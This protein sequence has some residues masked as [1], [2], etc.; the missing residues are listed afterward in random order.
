MPL[1]SISVPVS[2]QVLASSAS[3]AIFSGTVLNAKDEVLLK[4]S[5]V[6]QCEF[7]VLERVVDDAGTQSLRT[8][9]G[10]PCESEDDY[11]WKSLF[12]AEYELHDELQ[13]ITKYAKEK[14]TFLWQ[15]SREHW[16]LFPGPGIYDVIFRFL[17]N[18]PEADTL[19]LVYACQVGGSNSPNRG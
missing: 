12:P 8:L 15:P 16:P 9:D 1:G 5:E 19:L 13:A 2:G 4:P 14:Y 6:S 11:P 7:C 17:R 10:T 3:L 18:D